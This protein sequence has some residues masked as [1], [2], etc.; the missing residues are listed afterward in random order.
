M[1]IMIHKLKLA[2]EKVKPNEMGGLE[3]YLY[4]N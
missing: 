3:N 4:L 1:L 2:R